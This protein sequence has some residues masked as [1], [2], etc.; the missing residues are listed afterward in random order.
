MAGY[1]ADGIEALE[2]VAASRP[3]WLLMDLKMPRMNG[4]HATCRSSSITLQ[5]RWRS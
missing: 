5:S 3:M 2:Q 1:A 4:I